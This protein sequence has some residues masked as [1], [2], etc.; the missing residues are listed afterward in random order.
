MIK[1]I[2]DS[3]KHL[4][5]SPGIYKM[6]AASGEILYIGKA[7]NLR[8][9]VAYYTKPGLT[10]RL[11]RMVELVEIVEF[12]TTNSEAEALLL[13][14]RL[15][16]HHQPKYNILLK[17][18]KSFPY[19]KLRM[20]HDFPQIVKLRSKSMPEGKVYGPFASTNDVDATLAE[21]QKIF[22][23]R[24]CSDNYFAA[25]KRPCLQYQIKRCYAPCVGKISTT[26]YN[27]LVLQ[28]EDFLQGKT[29]QLQEDL[30]KQMEDLSRDMQYEKAG[31]IRDR[32]KA[33]SYVQMKFGSS[34][35]IENADIIM[36]SQKLSLPG[37]LSRRGNLENNE[38]AARDDEAFSSTSAILVA[39]YRNHQ[40]Y[41]NHVYFM[42][43]TEDS[44]EGEI[45]A[46]FIEQFYQDKIPPKELITSHAIL[47]PTEMKTALQSLHKIKVD[48]STPS[49]GPKLQ[50]LKTF[51]DTL[52][53][54]LVKKIKDEISKAEIWDELQNL[55]NLPSAPELIEVYDNSHIMGQYAIGAFIAC[56]RKG[57]IRKKYR[58][59]N[60]ESTSEYGGDDYAMLAEVL[61]RRI[62]KIIK[63]KDQKPD[64]LIIDGGKGHLSTVEVVMNKL[65]FHIPFVCM[66]KGPDRN[67]GREQFH[68]TGRDVF[69]LDKDDKLMR[70]LQILR[71]EA[72]NFAIKSHRKKRSQNMRSSILDD[73]EGIGP[74][75]KKDLLHFFGSSAAVKN[76]SLEELENIAGLGKSM[77]RKIFHSL[78]QEIN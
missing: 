15:V 11:T 12:I 49:R 74:K 35:E 13:E 38:L 10:M 52:Q 20:D 73:I 23:L 45:I 26:E 3:I 61:K 24:S 4:P 27:A 60:L 70:Y 22:K 36:A 32:I 66:S 29:K 58:A 50:L 56:G 65:S 17:D 7:K 78:H 59:Y 54:A 71:D 42:E 25:R 5:T 19:I 77:A 8:V 46:G 37:S 64:L 62:E 76:A 18:D 69:T 57:F 40:Y 9:R 43:G 39:F 28:V 51:E 55:F 30:A 34:S 16:K 21:L 1:N 53:K 47:N 2:T 68:M 72:H 63:N 33:L 6:L 44:D 48:I 14:A 75:R 67:A 31:E 41:G